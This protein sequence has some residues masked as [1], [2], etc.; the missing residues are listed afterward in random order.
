MEHYK[1]FTA[2][3]TLSM[4]AQQAFKKMLSFHFQLQLLA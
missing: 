1:T 2:I 3:V 4:D